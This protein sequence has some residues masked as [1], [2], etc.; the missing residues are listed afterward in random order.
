VREQGIDPDEYS[1]EGTDLERRL[2]N[3]G[4][5][6]AT[7]RE[8]MDHAV[9]DAA[10]VAKLRQ[11]ITENLALL[12]TDLPEIKPPLPRAIPARWMTGCIRSFDPLRP[13]YAFS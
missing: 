3:T 6:D 13:A 7:V 12:P 9:K 8:V 4:T 2:T 11:R 5:N 10:E 1:F